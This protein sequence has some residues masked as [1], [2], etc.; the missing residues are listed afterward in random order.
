MSKI[1]FGRTLVLAMLTAMA[2]TGG[3]G[4]ADDEPLL[5]FT[6]NC[7]P[8]AVPVALGQVSGTLC[9]PDNENERGRREVDVL[10]PGATYTRTYWDWPLQPELYSYVRHALFAGRATFA[11]DP[12]GRGESSKPA[13]TSVTMEADAQALHQVITHL[14]SNHGMREVNVV[15]HSFGSMIAVLET[16]LYHDAARLV[17]TG[18]QHSVGPGRG[19][20]YPA[21]LDPQFAGIGYDSGWLTTRPG[22]RGGVFYYL[23]TADPAVIAYDEAHKSVESQTQFLEGLAQTYTPAGE[24][25]S[26]QITVPVMEINGEFDL[27]ACTGPALDCSNGA[28]VHAFEV[29]YYTKAPILTTK[30]VANTGH[31]LNLHP[32]APETFEIINQWLKQ[33]FLAAE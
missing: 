17:L 12:L 16:A 24:N 4:Y 6:P 31:D 25:L 22:T 10:V 11:F 23:K 33:P 29:P 14:I 20:Y 1:G 28:A 8:L 13:S 2:L 32:T 30:I 27:F 7:H 3:P 5:K 18:L 9:L 19:D 15:G 21:N 26:N